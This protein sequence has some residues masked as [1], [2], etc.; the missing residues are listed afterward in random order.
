VIIAA[1]V[2]GRQAVVS[3]F[4]KIKVMQGVHNEL[5]TE[6]VGSIRNTVLGYGKSK[7]GNCAAA[8]RKICSVPGG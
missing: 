7:A 4:C 8:S 1:D 5:G 3:E 2:N 6:S